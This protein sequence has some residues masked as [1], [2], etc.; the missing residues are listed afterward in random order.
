MVLECRCRAV[1]VVKGRLVH[2]LQNFVTAAAAYEVWP[3]GKLGCDADRAPSPQQVR[4][5]ADPGIVASTKAPK[6]CG[7][8]A[9]SSL[10][11]TA[12]Q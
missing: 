12:A 9:T 2:L 10:G 1:G 3:A 7:G 6:Y 4:A 11:H 8:S 5:S